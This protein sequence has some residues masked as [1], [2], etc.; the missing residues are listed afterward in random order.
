MPT[1]AQ[2]RFRDRWI[3]P[4]A[5]IRQGVTIFRWQRLLPFGL[6]SPLREV[7]PLNLMSTL[8]AGSRLL[9]FVGILVNLVIFP[10]NHIVGSVANHGDYTPFA[11]VPQV[12]AQV[13]DETY[14]YAPDPG[15][16]LRTGRIPGEV[17]V[18]EMRDAPSSAPVVH[19]VLVG[20][21]AKWMGSLERAWMV[22]NAIGPTLIWAVL[23]CNACRFTR[24]GPLAM[25]IAWAVC[26][27]A[28]GPRNFL[29]LAK[30]R[31]IQPLELTRMP[32]PALAFL[33]L[34]LA[35]W[36]LSR[37]LARTNPWRILAAGILAG[38]LFYVY[39]FYWVAFFAGAGSLLI[40]AAIIKRWDY[41]KTIACIVVLG[42]LAGIPFFLWTIEATRS[43]DQRQ[44]MVRITDF[45]RIPDLIGLVLALALAIALWLYCSL[46]IR[47][48]AD[49]Q[50][51]FEAALLAVA[52]GA[53][54]GLN[55]QLLTGI[56]AQHG[57]F[58]NRALQPLL[59]YLFLLMLFRRVRKPPIAATA[60]VIGILI[61]VASLRQIEVGRNTAPWHRKSSPDIDVLLWARAHLP[62]DSVIGSNDANLIGLIPAI[63][64]TWTFV[65]MGPRSMASNEEILTRYSLLCRLEG[66]NWQEVEAELRRTGIQDAMSLSYTLVSQPKI[67]SKSIESARAIWGDIDLARDFR[68]R[69]LDYVVTRQAD[70]ALVPPVRSG[71]FDI[72]YQNS[73][74]RLVRVM[75]R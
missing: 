46:R 25:A 42:C 53:A 22:S 49:E 37:A 23:F 9:L 45:N 71:R 14:Q 7:L 74:W 64:G 29:L 1:S 33:F 65:P 6:R 47:A 69:R 18:F 40:V 3:V 11:V 4:I 38:S 73:A 48:Q 68:D 70:A 27:I 35:I 43:G 57:H 36:L 39:Y 16:F 5:V 19:A 10:L 58:Y 13:Y 44:L 24:S 59:M 32:Q 67:S 15:R 2:L 61:A 62:P 21:L 75:S 55:F 31:F 26:F 20:L 50:P 52:T 17:D 8:P 34:I 60:A 66:R 12:S 56:N 63:A 54:I 30:D 51:L 41:V 28:F 72:L